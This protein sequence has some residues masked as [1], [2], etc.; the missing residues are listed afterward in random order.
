MNLLA[1]VLFKDA[2]VNLRHLTSRPK[3]V[4]TVIRHPQNQVCRRGNAFIIYRWWHPFF[5]VCLHLEAAQCAGGMKCCHWA[6]L[7]FLKRKSIRH[8]FGVLWWTTN[9]H[10]HTKYTSLAPLGS[11]LVQPIPLACLTL[12]DTWRQNHRSTSLKLQSKPACKDRQWYFILREPWRAKF[13]P[14]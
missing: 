7:N 9:P 12:L 1:A 2:W 6:W 8:C 11:W 5:T 10:I 4:T 14:L 3:S 13:M